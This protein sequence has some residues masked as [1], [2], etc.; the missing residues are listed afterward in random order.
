MNILEAKEID[1]E[2]RVHSDGGVDD[3]RLYKTPFILPELGEKL[4]WVKFTCP[5]TNSNYLISVNPKHKKV[6]DAVLDS[7][8]FY[9]QE[10]LSEKDYKFA[11]RG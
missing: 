6:M 10:I 7:C 2:M 5:S 8:P 3:L 9:G 4:A 11:A 1:S